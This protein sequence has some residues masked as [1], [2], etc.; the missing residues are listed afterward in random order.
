[1]THRLYLCHGPSCSARGALATRQALDTAL[2]EAGLLDTVEL[3]SSGCQDHCDHGPNLL[4][5]PGACRY[6]GVTPERAAAIVARHVR[7]GVPVE[8]WLATP[9]MR[10]GTR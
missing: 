1:M 7:D 2:W 3:Q 9:A 8:E 10:R 6:A 4:V 5:Y